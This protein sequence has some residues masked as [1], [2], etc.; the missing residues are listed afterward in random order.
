MR[1][2]VRYPIGPVHGN[3][4][5]MRI[6][7]DPGRKTALLYLLGIV[8]CGLSISFAVTSKVAAYYP[9]NAATRPITSAKMWQQENVEARAVSPLQPAPTLFL[10]FLVMAA[11]TQCARISMWMQTSAEFCPAIQLCSRRAQAIRPPPQN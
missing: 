4:N 9:H 8:F 2:G 7:A 10:I 11:T 6:S 3:L 5:M 1:P